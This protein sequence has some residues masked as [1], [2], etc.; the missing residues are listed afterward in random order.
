MCLSIPE[1]RSENARALVRRWRS[2]TA[3]SRPVGLWWG[4]QTV[5][6]GSSKLTNSAVRESSAKA[7]RPLPPSPPLRR[8]GV[9][10]RKSAQLNKFRGGCRGCSPP[11]S[12]LS[13]G[14]QEALRL[15]AEYSNRTCPVVRAGLWA[16]DHVA[17]GV[18]RARQSPEVGADLQLSGSEASEQSKAR[19][20]PRRIGSGART[21]HRGQ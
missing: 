5:L 3:S 12:G 13:L 7:D 2:S 14:G 6:S 18:G 15:P 21:S 1:T 17:I 4:S 9:D 8:R 16:S 20:P 19:Q 10:A 11:T